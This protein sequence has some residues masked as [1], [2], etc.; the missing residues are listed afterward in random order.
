M[1]RRGQ[2]LPAPVPD[3][4]ISIQPMRCKLRKLPQGVATV[5]LERR[6]KQETPLIN[7]TIV[8]K[9]RLKTG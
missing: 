6:V 1:G 4:L 8:L 2:F 7:D 5:P 9:V 3:V